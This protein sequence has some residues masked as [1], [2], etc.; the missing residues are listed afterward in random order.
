MLLITIVGLLVGCASRKPSPPPA[1]DSFGCPSWCVPVLTGP[2]F[3]SLCTSNSSTGTH[4]WTSGTLGINSGDV[5]TVLYDG[6]ICTN[7]AQPSV[8]FCLWCPANSN[9]VCVTRNLPANAQG[10][11]WNYTAN[12]TTC[13]PNPVAGTA[14]ACTN[15]SSL[16]PR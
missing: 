1:P 5:V 9:T 14:L 12:C 15:G 13:T 11:S 2:H 4:C 8:Q 6:G 3:I 7:G 10:M 16:K